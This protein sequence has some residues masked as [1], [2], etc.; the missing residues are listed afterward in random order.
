ME[1]DWVLSD[2]KSTVQAKCKVHCNTDIVKNYT[3]R[4]IHYTLHEAELYSWTCNRCVREA[5]VVN[6]MIIEASI[7]HNRHIHVAPALLSHGICLLLILMQK[8]KG[9]IHARIIDS[10]IENSKKWNCEFSCRAHRHNAE[11]LRN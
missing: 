6:Y 2:T 3:Y 11:V 10:H 8:N 5:V 4:P 7:R 1:I 9:Y